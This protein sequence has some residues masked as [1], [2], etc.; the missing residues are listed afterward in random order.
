MIEILRVIIPRL[1][2]IVLAHEVS[3][4]ADLNTR[5]LDKFT[6]ARFKCTDLYEKI[7]EW[8]YENRSRSFVVLI[9]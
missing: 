8:E 3:I 1:A 2:K 5:L 9:A 6:E 7:L 4:P